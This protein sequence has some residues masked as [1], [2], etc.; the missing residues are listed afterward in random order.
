MF[1]RTLPRLELLGPL[2]KGAFSKQMCTIP[3]FLN[4]NFEYVEHSHKYFYFDT[5]VRK[6]FD[7][8]IF[9]VGT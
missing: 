8:D 2:R 9:I 3:I 4:L 7:D 1:T 5:A 6:A